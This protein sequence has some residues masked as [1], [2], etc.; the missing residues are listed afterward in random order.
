[1]ATVRGS[2]GQGCDP[3]GGFLA[4][5]V[6]RR[7]QPRVA[8]ALA[9]LDRGDQCHRSIAVLQRVVLHQVGAQHRRLGCE[10]RDKPRFLRNRPAAVAAGRISQM[11]ARVL[12]DLLGRDLRAP[13][14]RSAESRPTPA[15]ARRRSQSPPR[16]CF[17]G[18]HCASSFLQALQGPLVLP[19]GT[20]EAKVEGAVGPPPA[21]RG[22]ERGPSGMSLLGSTGPD[23]ASF[24]ATLTSPDSTRRVFSARPARTASGPCSSSSWCSPDRADAPG[25]CRCTSSRA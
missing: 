14:R 8:V 23:P 2:A 11:Q 1:M 21:H 20:S 4:V 18:R 24:C 7:H 10:V 12:G 19:H 6:A 16:R 15:G 17:S 3:G 5:L 22:V 13:L 25:N 9:E